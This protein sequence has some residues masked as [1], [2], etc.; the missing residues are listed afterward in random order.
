MNSLQ[1]KN[2]TISD[3]T[4][5]PIRLDQTIDDL[6]DDISN[7]NKKKLLLSL[8]NNKI[9]INIKHDYNIKILTLD[10]YI[11]F[12][13]IFKSINWFPINI[14]NI[15]M[16]HMIH[17]IIFN[18]LDIDIL[19][20]IMI[21][22][23]Y[24]TE[25]FKIVDF[26]DC[27]INLNELLTFQ[28]KSNSDYCISKYIEENNLYIESNNITLTFIEK[29]FS[30]YRSVNFNFIHTNFDYNYSELLLSTDDFKTLKL[31]LSETFFN[32]SLE[33]NNIGL[34]NRIINLENDITNLKHNNITLMENNNKYVDVINKLKEC[35][36]KLKDKHTL[37]KNDITD[38]KDNNISLKSD[39]TDLKYINTSLKNDI[40]DLK[41]DIKS[42]KNN[43]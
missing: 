23:Y 39:I 31:T 18:D 24:Q 32:K 2:S 3:I 9:Y 33:N 40:T 21:I 30:L 7:D 11:Y 5:L 10:S 25:S 8:L 17:L 6:L 15:N 26:M 19:L 38:L 27:K 4:H 12:Y 34:K 16:T 42:L 28:K 13:S 36:D 43:Y 41:N 35:Y 29:I 37:L 14:Y 20:N 1:M 22:L